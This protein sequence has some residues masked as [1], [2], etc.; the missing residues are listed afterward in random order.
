MWLIVVTPGTHVFLRHCNFA[1]TSILPL[2]IRTPALKVALLVLRL[3]RC[4]LYQS[5]V[6]LRDSSTYEMSKDKWGWEHVKFVWIFNCILIADCT[7]KLN[8]T[9]I[10][11]KH[12]TSKS[13]RLWAM[14]WSASSWFFR[15]ANEYASA[16]FR[17]SE[18]VFSIIWPDMFVKFSSRIRFS[19]KH[20]N[21][22]KQLNIN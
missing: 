3:L 19:K 5:L 16:R 17:A 18:C 10:W 22:E 15:I 6:C 21:F 8:G 9:F 7:F 2:I 20:E 14:A 12:I 4:N 1:K 13:W 11:I